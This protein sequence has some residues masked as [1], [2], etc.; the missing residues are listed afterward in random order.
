VGS[1]YTN[2]TLRTADQKRVVDALR[3]ARRQAIVSPPAN[4]CT[5]VFDRES[6]DQDI[7]VLNELAS[8]LS[9]RLGCPAL[10]VLNHD[11][12]VLIYTLHERGEL[13]DDYN[14]SP[15]YFTDGPGA[16]PEGGDAERLCHAFG[17]D[18]KREDVERV[19]RAPWG[20][21]GFTFELERHEALVSALGLPAMAVATGYNYL[22]QGEFPEGATSSDYVRI[23]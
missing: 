21:D 1:F 14:S 5:V 19:L 12:D 4:S 22:D 20:A 8:S 3:A 11:D 15:A 16:E 18:G 13:V 2:V 10:A 17:A 7:D 23:D 6:E 9:G